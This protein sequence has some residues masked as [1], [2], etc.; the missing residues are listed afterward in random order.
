MFELSNQ[1]SKEALT[2]QFCITPIDDGYSIVAPRAE[3]ASDEKPLEFQ[4]TLEKAITP[5]EKGG[6]IANIIIDYESDKLKS[7]LNQAGKLRKLPESE[8][9]R[10]LLDLLRLNMAFAYDDAVEQLSKVNSDLSEW[11]AKNTGIKS[12]G[13]EQ[14]SLSEIVDSGYGVC[15]HLSVIY[16]T[17]AKEAGLNGAY[18][19]ISRTDNE[20]YD[21]R[22]II[23]PDT[24]KPLFRMIAVGQSVNGHAWIELRLSDNSWIPV[25]PSTN[26]VGDTDEGLAIFRE[27]NYRA[28]PIFSFDIEGLPTDVRHQGIVDLSFLPGES[29]HTGVI[30]INSQARTKPLRFSFDLKNKIKLEDDEE[31]SEPTQYD[32]PLN[33]QIKSRRSFSSMNVK[34]IN[35]QAIK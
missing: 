4:V 27:A 19:T 24:G 20:K 13:A 3:L 29:I 35:V 8:R 2:N 15:R 14:L 5:I 17:L 7:M 25:D 28:L 30:E 32:G 26:L 10:K 34:V 23:R 18:L 16:L 33:F 11:I 22:N 12:D 6:T 1:P 21:L 31:W 9:P